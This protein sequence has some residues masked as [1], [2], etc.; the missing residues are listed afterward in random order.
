MSGKL[1]LCITGALT[2][3]IPGNV[4]TQAEALMNVLEG[5]GHVI[6]AASGHPN[7]YRRLADI[8]FTLMSHAREIDL[9]ILQVYSGPSFFQ[10]D[11]ASLLARILGIPTI[12]V[13]HGGA[14][15]EFSKRHPAWVRRVL[16]RAVRVVSPSQYLAL[17]LSVPNA[18]VEIIPNVIE[19]NLYPFRERSVIRPDFFWMRSFFDYYRPEMALRAAHRLLPEYPGLHLTMAGPDKGTL[20]QMRLLA[21]EMNMNTNVTFGGFL[22]FDAKIQTAGRHEVYLHTNAVDNMPVSV[23]EMLALGLPVVATSVGGIPYM[24]EHEH[25]ALLVPDGDDQAMAEA[26]KRLLKDSRL[27]RA[28][29]Q[30]GRQLAAGSSAQMVLQKWNQLLAGLHKK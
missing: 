25:T 30:N 15:P 21:D 13:L 1:K 17:N 20:P 18:Q 10:A 16:S 14:L 19:L 6:I 2:G 4:P 11:L 9:Q 23:L 7:R 27:V 12:M 24:L 29:S 26:M 28:L 22:D 5:Q 3:Q 8:L